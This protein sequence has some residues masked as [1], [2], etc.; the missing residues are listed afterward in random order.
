[1]KFD[2]LLQIYWTYKF[3][4]GGKTYDFSLTP[5]TLLKNLPGLSQSI[6][7]RYFEK[8]EINQISSPKTLIPFTKL[9]SD[10]RMAMNFFLGQLLNVNADIFEWERINSL[11]KFL[12][13]S[14]SGRALAIGKPVR[15][16][17]THSNAYTA[18]HLK[19]PF[20]SFIS[21]LRQLH[22]QKLRGT[23]KW[24]DPRI[25]QSFVSRLTKIIRRRKKQVSPI[26]LKKI[27]F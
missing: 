5:T 6:Q 4:Y 19:S 10:Q 18:K 8:Y 11:R 12:I 9:K 16:Q 22:F 21:S 17:R 3:L 1:L 26:I 24:K 27:W 20:K 13:K 25:R 7:N 2:H 14:Y 15:G 23:T